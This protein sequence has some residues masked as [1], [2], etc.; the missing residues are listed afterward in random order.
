MTVERPHIHHVIEYGYTA[1][2]RAEAE[3]Y[4]FLGQGTLPGPQRPAGPRVQ[5]SDFG[6][7]LGHIHHAIDDD[8]RRF[9]SASSIDLVYPRRFELAYVGRRQPGQARESMAGVVP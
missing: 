9:K 5:S 7:R 1:V 6:R 8:W 3:H 2:C 4:E